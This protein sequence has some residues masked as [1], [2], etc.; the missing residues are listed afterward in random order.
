MRSTPR[1]DLAI[2]PRSVALAP[3]IATQRR[4]TGQAEGR[5]AKVQYVA[6]VGGRRVPSYLPGAEG[7]GEDRELAPRIARRLADPNRRGRVPPAEAVAV[8]AA[9][10]E[11]DG[12]VLIAACEGLAMAST[13]AESQR[14]ATAYDFAGRET[15]ERVV[16]LMLE[17]RIGR[18]RAWVT[19]MVQYPSTTELDVRVRP[20]VQDEKAPMT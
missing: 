6:P 19:H 12:S 4:A 7:E 11:A 16:P 9:V 14:R 18:A 20:P 2:A 17:G 3:I 15:P 5:A 1:K 13:R 8:W 10:A